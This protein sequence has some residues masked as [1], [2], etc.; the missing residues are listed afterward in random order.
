MHRG[1]HIEIRDKKPA[2]GKL[3]GTREGEGGLGETTGLGNRRR[4]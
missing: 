4:T 2:V 1:P 3:V